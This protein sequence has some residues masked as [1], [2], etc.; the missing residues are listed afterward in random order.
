[1]KS[2]TKKTRTCFGRHTSSFRTVEMTND[3]KYI[4][5]CS[6]DKTIRIWNLSEKKKLW[7]H[8]FSIRSI[9]VISDNKYIVS[10]SWD[11]TIR[12]WSLLKKTRNCLQGRLGGVNSVAI[13]SDN[14]YVLWI[15][16]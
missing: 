1:M 13:T 12:V 14:K 2:F 9:T 15:R 11:K 3:N 4:I 6:E 8:T 7:G 10:G 5:S 16:Q